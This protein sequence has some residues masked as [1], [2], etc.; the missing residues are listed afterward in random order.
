VRTYFGSIGV[1]AQDNVGLV[2]AR[3]SP[4]EFISMSRVFRKATDALGTMTASQFSK[5]STLGDTSGRWGDYSGTVP[6][7]FA[8][9]AFW[10]YHEYRVPAGWATWVGLMGPCDTPAT[11]CTAKLTS[12]SL[13]PA[14]GFTG[15][16]SVGKNNLHI[17]MINGIPNKSGL[18]FYG[19]TPGAIP[20]MGGTKCVLAPTKR[21]PLFT[22]DAFGS[23]DLPVPVTLADLGLDQYY[24]GYFRDSA[25]PDGTG[26]GL[27]NALQLRFCP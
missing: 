22:L 9:G 8:V 16:P 15:E 11:Y 19:A 2:F 23:I 26:V 21:T 5:V 6:D 13:L 12:Q 4:T 10:G 17:T 1:D 14:I 7:P 3:S 18:F 27:S 25:H 24:Q 20:F